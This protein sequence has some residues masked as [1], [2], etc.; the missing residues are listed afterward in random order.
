MCLEEIEERRIKW[1]GRL[2]KVGILSEVFLLYI[3]S[4]G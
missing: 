3:G 4:G 2:A 1:Y